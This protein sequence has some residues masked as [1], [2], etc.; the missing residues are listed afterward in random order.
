MQF[1]PYTTGLVSIANGDTTL[2]F[3]GAVIS[4]IVARRGDVIYVGNENPGVEILERTDNSHCE[5][6][7]PWSGGSK[8]NVPFTIVP[9]FPARV[10]GVEAA[11]DVTRLVAALN[12]NGLP[13]LVPTD[14]AEPDPSWG[15]EEQTAI[16]P[17]T[18]KQ[19]HKEGGV[20]VYDGLF[21]AFGTPAPY[22]NAKAYSLND[23]ATLNGSSYVWVNAT[24]GSGHAPPNATYWDVLA[25][26]GAVGPGAT[27]SVGT[28]T[29][30]APGTSA[31][32]SNSGTSA[33]AVFNFTIPR[34]TPGAGDLSSSN[35][36]SELANKREAKD[37]ISVRGANIASTA[38]L[39]LESATGDLVDVTGTTTITAI[40][41]SDGHERTVRFTGALTLTHGSSLV[42][43]GGANITTAAGAFA[44]F[45]GYASGVVRCIDYTPAKGNVGYDP[46]AASA[47]D[48]AQARLNIGASVGIPDVI[49]EDQKPSG[50]H[51]GNASTGANT[52]NLNTFVRNVGSLA[53]LSSDQ[54]TLP[55]GTYLIAWS[56]PAW[57][58]DQH[59]SLLR[60]LTDGFYPGIGSSEYATSAADTPVTRSVGSVVLTFASTKVFAIHHMALTARATTGFGVAGNFGTGERYTR[61]EITKL[62]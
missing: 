41:L 2:T 47:A 58:I 1:P 10:A 13:W 51:G 28:V 31:S 38:T 5:I 27:V 35:N 32:V 19:W 60:N 24:P 46:Q 3:T 15:D 9:N 61:V 45:R 34:G 20:W 43:P 23:V 50:T 53:S 14:L 36:L 8:V 55:A 42:L 49:I 33:D 7:V 21:K 25:A 16:Q 59:Q 12:T 30:G 54:F 62:N 44:V 40:T 22:D 6:A 11:E 37:N 26:R 17:A 57:R 52:R 29:T 48:Q 56:A 18:G 39:D 4:D